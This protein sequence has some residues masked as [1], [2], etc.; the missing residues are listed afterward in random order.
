MRILTLI[1]NT[2]ASDKLF[3]EHGLSFYI[4]H[5]GYKII[6]DTGASDRFAKN[7]QRMLVNI[8]KLDAAVISHN[9]FDHTGGLDTLFKYCP[10]VK[11]F[12][13]EAVL[14]DFVKQVGI[15][16]FSISESK[17]YFDKTKHNFVLFK[18]FQKV[19]EGVFLLSNE[20]FDESFSCTDKSLLMKSDNKY[21]VDDFS[22]ELFMVVFPTNKTEDGCV[23]ISSCSHSGIIN[24]IKTVRLN[25]PDVIILGVVG[26]FH[27]MG[28]TAKQLGVS[29]EYIEITA[30]AIT[31]L[32]IGQIYTCHCTGEKGY[33]KLK[34]HLNDQIQ[35]LQTGEE[36]EF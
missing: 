35:Y 22:H 9:H 18:N 23:I 10:K 2:S 17:S 13:K 12:A 11:V 19:T 28:K 31:K 27:F 20:V 14:G 6:F 15:F 3:S 29:N 8:S 21:V 32:N 25:W 26:G 24:I 33:E 30:D 7:A 5:M 34:Q 4:E 1:E 36:L 16:K